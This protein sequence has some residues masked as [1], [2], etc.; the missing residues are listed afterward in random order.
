MVSRKKQWI[1]K[2]LTASVAMACAGSALAIEFETDG[3]WRGSL[4]TTVSASASWRAE[5]AHKD[6]I[7]QEHANHL[8]I[9]G[10]PATPQSGWA[11]TLTDDGNL[12]WDKGDRYQTLYKFVSELSLSKGDTGALVRVKGWYDQSLNDDNVRW[13]NGNTGYGTHPSRTSRKLSDA[14]FNALAKFDGLYL[15][16]AYAYTSV[17]VADQ[18][19]QLRLGRQAVNW[20][21]SLF[22]AGL[23]QLSPLDIIALRKAGTEIKEALLPVWSAYGNLGLPG[24]M[25]MEGY[26]QL[27]W[28]PSEVD[29]CGTFWGVADIAVSTALNNCNKTTLPLPG[30][31]DFP[32]NF[33]AG[34]VIEKVQG[35]KG[36][37]GKDSGQWGLALRVPVDAI[38]TEFGLYYMNINSRLPM[39]SGVYGGGTAANQAAAVGAFAPVFIQGFGSQLAAAGLKPAGATAL[40]TGLVTPGVTP[41]QAVGQCVLASGA[42]GTPAQGAATQACTAAA[43]SFGAGAT[44]ATISRAVGQSKSYWEYPNDIQIVGISAATNIMGWSTGWE[45]SYHKDVPVMYNVPDLL[46]VAALGAG[47]LRTLVAGKPGGTVIE[48]YQR[49]NKTQFQVNGVYLLPSLIGNTSGQLVAEIAAQSNNIP[50]S[51]G[52]AGQF[53]YGRASVFGAGGTDAAD[54]CWDPVKYAAQRTNSNRNPY[55]CLNE[56]YVDDFAWGYRVRA[57]LDYAGIF[58]TAWTATPTVFFLHD[59]KGYSMDGQ[60]TQD[61]Q[62]LSLGVKFS[63]NKVHNLEATYTTYSNKADYDAFRDRDNYSL[64]YSYTF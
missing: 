23:N 6:L 1:K 49:F 52:T 42:A 64:T 62:V 61:R 63:L 17:T 31:T 10:A 30:Q 7:W 58:D 50:R 36:K 59:V 39:I 5:A 16:D 4:N 12:N 14:N 29:S 19:L 28:E 46:Q 34:T 22:V 24:G 11:G 9:L 33:P 40:V 54:N 57:S 53:R 55:G 43:S 32:T 38:D 41:A 18:P 48:G 60:F 13:G 47:P 20:G 8:G 51:D 44:A 21:E 45:L 26:Y 27:K 25:S 15:L 56:G 2:S 35:I 37:D 3:G